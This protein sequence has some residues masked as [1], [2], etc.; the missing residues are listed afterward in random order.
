MSK[1][2]TPKSVPSTVCSRRF[3]FSSAVEDVLANAGDE[4]WCVRS[5]GKLPS[6]GVW[7]DRAAPAA[8][9][10]PGTCLAH[11]GVQIFNYFHVQ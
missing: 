5:L 9:Q 8:L 3:L 7:Q 10:P 11:A 1:Y 4:A 6:A 2:F